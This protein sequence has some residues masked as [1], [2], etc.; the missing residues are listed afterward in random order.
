MERMAS[1]RLT[2]RTVSLF[3]YVSIFFI[4]YLDSVKF[5]PLYHMSLHDSVMTCA[6]IRELHYIS[7]SCLHHFL[8]F[9]V[10]NIVSWM[11]LGVFWKYEIIPL[12]HSD[13]FVFYWGIFRISIYL[14]NNFCPF[15][16]IVWGN[17]G[18]CAFFTQLAPIS[19]LV[20]GGFL[21]NVK[22]SPNLFQHGY[23]QL[24]ILLENWKFP[25]LTT[26]SLSNRVTKISMLSR[27]NPYDFLLQNPFC[28]CIIEYK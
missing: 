26:A 9:P 15:F 12:F 18:I 4:T 10:L 6:R 23:P 7:I 2:I 17:I 5:F 21:D 22:K 24:G 8:F 3:I 13:I 20:I 1:T 25:Q 28:S 16:K 14:P 27:K 19:R 11:I